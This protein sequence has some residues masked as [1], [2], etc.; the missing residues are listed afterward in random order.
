[1]S[2]NKLVHLKPT[3]WRAYKRSVKRFDKLSARIAK[4][5]Y[6]NADEGLRNQ[7]AHAHDRMIDL[8][9]ECQAI[10]CAIDNA[11][12]PSNPEDVQ[13]IDESFDSSFA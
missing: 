13:F 6:D 11:V 1:M 4:I 10:E 3:L 7:R 2:S 5:G 12:D 9:G 8:A